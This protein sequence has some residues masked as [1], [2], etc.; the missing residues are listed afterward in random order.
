MDTFLTMLSCGC[1][2]L[3]ESVAGWRLSED[4]FLSA[5]MT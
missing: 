4:M 2:Y 5:N 3:S 1:L